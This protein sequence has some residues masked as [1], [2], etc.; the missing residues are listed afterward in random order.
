MDLWLPP[1]DFRV[2]SLRKLD[3]SF[4]STPFG[5]CLALTTESHLVALRFVANR[6]ES[7][8]DLQSR[9][10]K[11]SLYSSRETARLI[12]MAFEHPEKIQVIAVGTPFQLTI[13]EFLRSI[14][15]GTT[16][17]YGEVA[18]AIGRPLAARA[19]GQAVG[20]NEIAVVIPCHRVVSRGKLTGYRWGLERKR[21]L[22]AGEL[23][24]RQLLG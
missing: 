23:S 11:A 15:P 4:A 6:F 22:L 5:D 14:P 17:T 19:V 9:W 12:P 24:E 13:W 10:P 7:L 1:H 18:A 16:M 3:Y 2:R 20:A 8:A 21:Q